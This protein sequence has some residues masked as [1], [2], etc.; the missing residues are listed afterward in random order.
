MRPPR[1]GG[2]ADLAFGLGWTALGV[3]VAVGAWR[4]DR[5][6]HQGVEPYAV[7]G[8]L[9]G[10]LGVLLI[11]LGLALALRGWR[12][13]RRAPEGPAEERAPRAE[14]WRVALALAL[15]VGFAAGALGR[16]PPFWLAAFLFVLLSILLFEWPER[17][18]EGTLV[19]GAA[20]AF[21]IAAAGSAAI[22][23][24]FQEVFL[25]RLP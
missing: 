3:A 8:L 21:A 1:E 14:P 6:E 10:L 23:L 24:V 16:G 22:T 9:P 17:R 15:S 11:V 20:Q 18:R 13:G 5:L 19:R 12:G 2:R 4:M 7:P 25:V